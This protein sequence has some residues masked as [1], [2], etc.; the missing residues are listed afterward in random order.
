MRYVVG[1]RRRSA[2]TR[3]LS[4]TSTLV[5]LAIV[6]GCAFTNPASV[7]KQV[8]APAPSKSA[9]QAPAPTCDK[10]AGGRYLGLAVGPSTSFAQTEKAMGITASAT[11]LYYSIGAPV[12][13]EKLASLC[14]KHILPI[15]DID[16]D[17]VPVT[18]VASGAEDRYLESLAAELGTLQ[19]PVGVDINHEFNGPWFP[20][21]Y[22][23]V[24]PAQF[25]AMWRHIVTLFRSNGANNVIW[26]WNP[27]VTTPYTVQDLKPFYPGDAYVDWVGFDGYFYDHHD[28]YATVFGYTISQVRA[29]TKRP[30]FIVET[31]ANQT[32]GRSRAIHSIFAGAAK[33]PGLLGLIY[34]DENKTSV[35]DWYINDDPPALT[36]FRAGASAYLKS[37]G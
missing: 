2:I 14:A 16:T 26:V 17:N 37:A 18:Q 6:S 11:T 19:T 22:P 27:N 10:P 7:F 21:S 12:N 25:V 20:W 31:G 5:A 24:A 33:T 1:G 9:A 28:T 3:T 23:K 15:V 4:T 8:R 29:F 36:A 30:M 13:I 34:F 35:H 32:S